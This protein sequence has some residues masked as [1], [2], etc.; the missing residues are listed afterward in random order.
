MARPKVLCIQ[1]HSLRR[2]LAYI[3]LTL[4][5]PVAA[6]AEEPTL[7][8]AMS[9]LESWRASFTS[10][11]ITYEIDEGILENSSAESAMTTGEYYWSEAKRFY[12]Y[13]RFAEDGKQLSQYLDWGDGRISGRAF[14][15][16]GAGLEKERPSTLV[17]GRIDP[18]SPN[19]A[20]GRAVTALYG[21]WQAP[22]CRWLPEILREKHVTS[23]VVSLDGIQ[24]LEIAY[25]DDHDKPHI[26]LVLDPRYS[27]LPRSMLTSWHYEV[28]Q[29]KRFA[30]GIWMPVAGVLDLRERKQAWEI[31]S[32]VFNQDIADEKVRTPLP[33]DGARITDMIQGKIW[34]HGTPP[35]RQ[36]QSEETEPSAIPRTGNPIVAQP[37]RSTEN[38]LPAWLTLIGGL[39]L[40]ISAFLGLRR[41]NSS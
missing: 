35:P 6:I 30:P 12:W 7:D 18:Q 39:A 36:G 9:A 17:Y 11:H 34:Y 22:T 10:I 1:E 3:C 15:P 32:V 26:T 13:E 14:Y 28:S 16:R 5:L 25:Q 33:G 19:G 8:E 41:G 20:V 40:G 23:H 27:Y 38:L 37:H 31:T 29:F 24:C 21:L 2:G 4:L